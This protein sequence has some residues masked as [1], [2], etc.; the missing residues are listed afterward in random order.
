MDS[1]T[2]GELAYCVPDGIV[3][4]A[5]Q[6]D[7]RLEEVSACGVGRF[8]IR[9]DYTMGAAPPSA[10]QYSIGVTE[11]G[12]RRSRGRR[13]RFSFPYG[14]DSHNPVVALVWSSKW[15]D[16]ILAMDLQLGA[17]FPIIAEARRASWRRSFWMARRCSPGRRWHDAVVRPGG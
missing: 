1:L 17:P 4:F 10:S 11:P 9:A 12:S 3:R 5:Q 7:E 16:Q 13:E 15:P 8:A 14:R 6:V 2:V